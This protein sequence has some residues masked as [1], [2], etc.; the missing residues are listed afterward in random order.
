[1]SAPILVWGAGAI[2]GTI[3][4]AFVRA[5][6]E[7]V[8]VDAVADHVAAINAR[9]L[10]IT[11]PIFEDTVRATA[12]LPGEVPLVADTAFL[13]VKAHHTEPAARAIAPHVAPGGFVVSAQNGLN[14]PVI[15]KI[16]GAERTIGCFV[17]FGADY[18]EPGV[19]HFGGRGAVVVGE[20]DGAQT[21]RI[22]QLHGLMQSFE[23]RAVLLHMESA[24]VGGIVEAPD[25]AALR[26]REWS[27][28][29]SRWGGEVKRDL[30]H[31]A[32]FDPEDESLTRLER[33]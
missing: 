17:N 8:F 3:G 4:A 21:P 14:E 1:M 13:C 27:L 7:V 11:G 19:V 26:Y 22:R 16:V 2:G 5:G 33:P 29:M 31:P 18:L 30:F 32:G 12:Y 10:R 25:V 20:L 6:H 9:G 28:F 15:A 24:S 23:P